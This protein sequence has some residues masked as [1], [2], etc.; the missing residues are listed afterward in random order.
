MRAGIFSNM[1]SDTQSQP[2]HLIRRN[3]REGDKQRNTRQLMSYAAFTVIH[4]IKH[5]SWSG[6]WQC[7]TQHSLLFVDLRV[8]VCVCVCVCLCVCV[9]VCV[10]VC[11]FVCVC[12][13]ACVRVCV[14]VRACVCVLVHA[15]VCVV[16]VCVCVCV[17]VW[18]ICIAF[19]LFCEC[20]T[21]G[22]APAVDLLLLLQGQVSLL[23]LV[24][25]YRRMTHICEP[26]TNK[27]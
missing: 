26:R 15:C 10:R 1:Q 13:R 7:Q 8:C 16:C 12:V 27:E 14:C 22:S 2:W 20:L 11:A 23:W 21:I 3:K 6:I 4:Y 18:N 24:T 9:F 17:C 19:D 5:F 25:S